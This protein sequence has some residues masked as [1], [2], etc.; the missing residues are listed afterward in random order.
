[1]FICPTWKR[2]QKL[3]RM[4]E[5]LA[6]TETS[7]P[8]FICINGPEM[9]AEYE[10]VIKLRPPNWEWIR[11][12][13]N[14]GWVRA[15][16][17]VMTLRPQKEWYGVINDDHVPMTKHWDQLMLKLSGPWDMVTCLDNSKEIQWRAS[18]PLICGGELLRTVGFFMPPCNWHICGDDWWQLVGR[19]FSLW[20]VAANV[21][22]DQPDS[23]IFALDNSADPNEKPDETHESSYQ[24]FG[25]QVMIYHRW[26]AEHGGDIMARLRVVLQANGALSDSERG[27]FVTAK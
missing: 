11:V 4:L 25:N 15:L 2:P 19:A 12:E 18:G 24:D 6:K 26:L 13:Q 7:A 27:R 1:M 20:R 16:N 14:V 21:R 3:K 22:V 10:E 5:A 8:G 17:S 9:W 23:A